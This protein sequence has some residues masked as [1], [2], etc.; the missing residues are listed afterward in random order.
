MAWE[1][2]LEINVVSFKDTLVTPSMSLTSTT[3]VSVSVSPETDS[4]G[5][6]LNTKGS[7]FVD[8]E[9]MSSLESEYNYDETAGSQ[10]YDFRLFHEALEEVSIPKKL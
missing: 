6:N 1:L 2:N 10:N 7:D 9:L 3:A 5:N 8:Y 4:A